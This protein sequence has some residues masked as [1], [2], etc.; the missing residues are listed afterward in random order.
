MDSTASESKKTG[1]VSDYRLAPPTVRRIY[2]TGR[3]PVFSMEEVSGG[4][5]HT[6]VPARLTLPLPCRR[7]SGCCHRMEPPDNPSAKRFSLS[8]QRD[9]HCSAIGDD[10]SIHR[11]KQ[12]TG[13]GSK[14]ALRFARCLPELVF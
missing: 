13:A 14:A 8:P 1:E 6:A 7:C 12:Q 5:K 2:M 9:N 10:V 11:R 4:A 3:C